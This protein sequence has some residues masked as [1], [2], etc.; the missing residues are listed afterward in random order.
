MK[1]AFFGTP[2]FAADILSGI[3]VYPDIEVVLVASQP[4]KPV[5]RKK[6]VFPTPVKKIAQEKSIEVL[7]PEKLKPSLNSLPEGEM[8]LHE[9]L[10]SL[11]LDF[12]VVVAYGKIIPQTILDIPKYG[13]I[14]IH[15]SILPLYR[16]A[17]PVQSAVK[18]GHQ[19]T[20]LTI[21]YMNKKM[22]EGDILR[23]Q[24]VSI[25]KD[26]TSIDIF[27]KFVSIA[28]KLLVET[29]KDIVSWDISGTSQD[30]SKATYCSMID[31]KDGEIDF[32]KFSSQ[33]IYNMFR[34]YQ[35]WPGIYTIF[36]GKKLGLE[37]ISLF[38]A[39]YNSPPTSLQERGDKPG[40]FVKLDKK[41]YGVVCADKKIL[42][43]HQ[44]K[45]EWKKSMDMVSFVNGNKNIVWFS[46]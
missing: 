29:L 9:K 30:H 19:E 36:D 14:N 33:E 37:N 41:N 8:Q 6:Q 3:V 42:L 34:G 28:P 18:D 43:L 13:C 17:S 45:P 24:K 46:F 5:W 26:D 23:I 21:M 32:Q 31:K 16:G 38:P 40:S 10:E 20:G 44:V 25:W 7:Q 12:I 27:Q 22:D 35:P 15:G 11:D 2:Q 4:D 1:I 39:W